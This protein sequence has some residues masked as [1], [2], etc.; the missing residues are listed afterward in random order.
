MIAGCHQSDVVRLKSSPQL[1]CVR[2]ML[3][4]RPDLAWRLSNNAHYKAFHNG[5]HPPL[6][7]IRI[8]GYDLDMTGSR[9]S[10]TWSRGFFLLQAYV[11]RARAL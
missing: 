2:Q 5:N 6:S 7:V 4:H 8:T 9:D 10:K 11:L 3:A 1:R